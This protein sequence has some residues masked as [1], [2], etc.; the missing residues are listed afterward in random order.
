MSLALLAGILMPLVLLAFLFQSFRRFGGS[1]DFSLRVFWLANIILAYLLVLPVVDLDILPRLLLFVPLPLAV[2][3]LFQQAFDSRRRVSML[4]TGAAAVGAGMMLLGESQNLL[5][6]YPD[7]HEILAELQSLKQQFSLNENDLVLG[8]YA[9]A[10]ACNWFLDTKAGLVTSFNRDDIKQYDRLFVLNTTDQPPSGT[11]RRVD[12]EPQKYVVMRQ[13]IP[14]PTSFQPTP[15]YQH[16]QFYQL[17]E[18]PASWQFDAS[19]N[20]S[21]W[22]DSSQPDADQ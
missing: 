3:L 2:V 22:S 21:G 4:L 8:P 6:M 7:K 5:R 12:T 18:I 9:V 16:L 20:W 14:L 17:E 19:G 15:G 11:A 1:L 10:P 13:Q